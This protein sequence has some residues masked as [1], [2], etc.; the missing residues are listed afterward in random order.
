MANTFDAET[1]Q[2]DQETETPNPG[3]PPYNPT[4]RI[5]RPVGTIPSMINIPPQVAVTVFW[6]A[7]G[8]GLCWW[9]S[10]RR[11]PRRD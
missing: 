1:G 10:N 8:F 3:F 9:L 2:V 7:V 5:A 4:Q 6:M 11:S